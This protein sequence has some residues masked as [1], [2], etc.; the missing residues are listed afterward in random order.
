VAIIMDGNG[1]WAAARGAPRSFGHTQGAEAVR[2]TVRAARRAGISCLTLYAFS[3]QNWARA[4]DEVCHLMALFVR[5]LAEEGAALRDNGIRLVVIGD[6]DRLP[7]PVRDAIAAAEATTATAHVMTLCLA[8]SY[9]G[10]ED[11]IAAARRLAREAR[12]GTLRPDDID[13][14][15]VS[16]ALSTR[17]LP[18]VDLVI[19]TSGEQRLSN[20]LL[21]EIA[22]AELHFTPRPWPEFDEADLAAALR[23]FAG[24]DRRF[25]VAPAVVSFSPAR[26]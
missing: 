7:A 2:R 22:Y 24:R 14:A 3:A 18:P 15:T 4:A 16:S 5:F 26:E 8:V 21:W 20:F 9:G 1:R 13:E 10:R 17:G 19:R 23:A 25:G 6:R 11:L 12:A